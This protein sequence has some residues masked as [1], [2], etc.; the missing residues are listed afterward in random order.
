MTTK[1]RIIYY[2]QTKPGYVSGSELESM[3][4]QWETKASVISRRCRELEAERAIEKI[5][6][7]K[8]TVAYRMRRSSNPMSTADANALLQ[9]LP[10]EP[11]KEFNQERMF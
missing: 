6:S 10:K 1:R 4:S 5:L 8:G 2:L 11:V 7:P 3:A 9:T